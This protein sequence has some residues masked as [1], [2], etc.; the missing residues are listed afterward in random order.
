M[1]KPRRKP[2][3]SLCMIVKN[4]ADSLAQCLKSVH[5]VA[6][7]LVVV[8]TGSTDSTVQIARSFG[9]AV[10]SSPWTGDFAAAR[11]AGLKMA[12]GT[13]ILILDADEELDAGSKE[14]LLLCA[15]HT[16][17]E[18]FFLRIHNH[19][20]TSRTSQTITVNPI[21][22]MF[23]N[24]PQYRFNG[25]IHEQIAGVIVEA[26][27]AAAMHLS[28][29]V[30]HH[31]GYADGVVA[32]K[33][34]ISRN[35]ELLKEQLRL[36][37][38]DAFHH[39]NMAVEYMRLGEYD[40]ALHHI[41]RSLEEVE[42]DTS[43]VHLLYKYEIRCRAAKRELKGA[44]EACERGIT[45]FPDYPDLHHLK[46]VL[47]LQAGAFAEAKAALRRALDIGVSPPGYHTES[48]F[49][50]YLTYTALGQLCQETG[51]DGEAIACCTRAAQLH[52]E[53]GPLIAR[54]LRIFK[55][56]GR[57]QE[58]TGWLKAH[59]PDAWA[60]LR[61]SLP[62]LLL[63]EGCYTAAVV[64]LAEAE[65]ASAGVTAGVDTAV[66]GSAESS[67][68]LEATTGGTAATDKATATNRLASPAPAAAE[69]GAERAA[70]TPEHAPEPD[71]AAAP[72]NSLLELIHRVRTIPAEQLSQ[73]D[74]LSLLNHPSICN[75]AATAFAAAPALQL[76]RSWILLADRVLA[77][78]PAAPV[79]GPAVRRAQMAL[80]LPRVTD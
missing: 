35:V 52:P 32:K 39:F 54:L 34:K 38:G 75:Q 20:G 29:V 57:E 44:L 66:L 60:A 73:G 79:Y 67:A 14:E 30:I 36:N 37:P 4:E 43:Y 31:Y 3:I 50:T 42:P 65:A 72:G 41:Q 77:S 33:D 55:Y 7:E 70:A 15:E 28:T 53:P 49:G 76:G 27:P 9:A 10:V 69:R 23:R 71:I 6:D 64:L 26:T 80:P 62:A 58:I 22:R 59:L 21:L 61:G 46:G 5:G 16:E 48:G 47:L 45:L 63:R 56:S 1:T 19:K 78:A 24:R 13:W 8:D 18:A 17:Y 2:L 11:N 51:E 25:I 12:K 40:P 74:V 68:V